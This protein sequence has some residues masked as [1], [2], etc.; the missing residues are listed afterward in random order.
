[1]V[2]DPQQLPPTCLSKAADSTKYNRSL[3][4]RLLHANTY[5]VNFLSIQY[6]M[7]PLICDFASK[8]FYNDKLET[9]Q[10]GITFAKSFHEDKLSKPFTF[11]SVD[12]YL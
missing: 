9:A 7:H 3:F 12:G 10:S 2:G 6:R 11:V 1:M 8:Y 5:E 4:E